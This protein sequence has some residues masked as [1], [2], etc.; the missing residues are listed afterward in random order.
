MPT[1][2]GRAPGP[3]QA[4]TAPHPQNQ[5]NKASK[6]TCAN[7]GRP[8]TAAPANYR[9]SECGL[10]NVILQGVTLAACRKCGHENVSIPRPAK[11]HRAIARA[12]ANSP[13]RLTGAELRFL[14]KHLGLNGAGFAR[15]LHT[16]KTKISKWET[17]QDRIGP[18]TDRLVRLLVVALD[19]DLAPHAAAVAGHLPRI[20]DEPGSEWELHLDARTLRATFLRVRR[21]A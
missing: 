21:A 1:N 2:D 11:V 9:Y 3:D 4:S 17:G 16:D 12:L 14:R 6:Q 13:A 19:K 15:F 20:A 7:C 8:V 10:P 18:A 5:M